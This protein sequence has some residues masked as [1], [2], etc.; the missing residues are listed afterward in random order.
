[1]SK[2]LKDDIPVNQRC[3]KL[4]RTHALVRTFIC[5]RLCVCVC[6]CV[7]VCERACVL[8]NVT[9]D[10]YVNLNETLTAK[11]KRPSLQTG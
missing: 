11:T 1:M 4:S 7:C 8:R 9:D 2:I 3:R 6:V 10:I 5:K